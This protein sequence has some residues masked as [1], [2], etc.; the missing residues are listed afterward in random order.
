MARYLFHYAQ[1]RVNLRR[2]NFPGLRR[3]GISVN[4]IKYKI[5][6]VSGRIILDKLEA[7]F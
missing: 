3:F 1:L 7:F 5:E 6:S 4:H 2:N